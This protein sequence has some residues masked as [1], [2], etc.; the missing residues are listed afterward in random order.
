MSE[1]EAD[2][3]FYAAAE[4]AFIRRRGTPFLLSPKDFALLKEWRALGVPLE[5]VEVQEQ[6]GRGDFR[7]GHGVASISRAGV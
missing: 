2:K 7:L 1:I 5:A 4:A 6:R 3:D